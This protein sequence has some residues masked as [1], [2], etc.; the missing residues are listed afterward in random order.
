[1][2]HLK[3]KDKKEDY[4]IKLKEINFYKEYKNIN[5]I[6]KIPLKHKLMLEDKL[7]FQD[8]FMLQLKQKLLLLL[9]L[10]VSIN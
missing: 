3:N 5:L 9:E 1:M 4:L 7:N 10:E 6:I 2:L 8:K